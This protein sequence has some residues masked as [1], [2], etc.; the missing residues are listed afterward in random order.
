MVDRLHHQ[1]ENSKAGSAQPMLMGH[2]H[3]GAFRRITWRLAWICGLVTITWLAWNSL[4]GECRHYQRGP[5]STAHRMFENDCAQCHQ[6]WGVLASLWDRTMLSVPDHKC[7]QCHDGLAHIP[8]SGSSTETFA[9]RREGACVTCHSEHDGAHSL[10]RLSDSACTDCH[11]DLNQVVGHSGSFQTRIEGFDAGPNSHPEF[12]IHRWLSTPDTTESGAASG[13]RHLAHT[14]ISKSA[15][16]NQLSNVWHDRSAIRFSHRKHLSAQLM[17]PHGPEDFSNRC[18]HCHSPDNQ[19]E[20]FGPIVFKQHCQRCHELVFDTDHL[21]EIDS[22]R[23]VSAADAQEHMS[24]A[25]LTVPHESPEAVRGFLID[26]FLKERIVNAAGSAGSAPR[27][28]REV[29]SGSPLNSDQLTP[30]SAGRIREIV[31]AAE[32]TVR[33]FLPEQE[34]RSVPGSNFIAV[35]SRLGQTVQSLSRSGG[36]RFC[37]EIQMAEHSDDAEGSRLEKLPGLIAPMWQIVPPAIPSPV[38]GS[39]TTGTAMPRRWFPHSRFNHDPH[40][41]MNCSE[42]HNTDSERAEDVLLPTITQCRNCHTKRLNSAHWLMAGRQ[43]ARFDCV[44]CHTYHHRESERPADGTGRPL[45][46]LIHGK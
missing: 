11:A 29:L 17:G 44:E 6:H 18:D 31:S 26:H 43:G 28:L 23:I 38:S 12:A 37:H 14:V 10:A 4:R 1:S 42:C 16:S 35:D 2:V 15:E 13:S 46:S 36:C 19:R 45:E 8:S 24:Y 20:Y 3:A 25:P 33:E 32:D 9:K 40:R 22:G 41:L 39:G 34:G 30:D 7:V 27:E 21:R 5:L